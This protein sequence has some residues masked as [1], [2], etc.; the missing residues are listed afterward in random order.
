MKAKGLEMIFFFESKETV[1]KR[2]TFHQEVSPIPLI[3]DP[4]KKWYDAYGLESSGYKS[5]ISH[6]TTFVQTAFKARALGVPMHPMADGESI[7]T[8]PAEFLLDKGLVIREVYYSETL[9]DRMSIDKIRAFAERPS[10]P[11]QSAEPNVSNPVL[12]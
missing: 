3:S 10:V 11:N 5:A 8:M 2:S 1:L 7:S 12:A 9:T 6:L 4:E